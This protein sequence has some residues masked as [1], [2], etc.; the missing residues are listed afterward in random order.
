MTRRSFRSHPQLLKLIHQHHRHTFDADR[1]NELPLINIRRTQARY[2]V[3]PHSGQ[4]RITKPARQPASH[5]DLR[6]KARGVAAERQ[7]PV[8]GRRMVEGPRTRQSQDVGS[9]GV[10]KLHAPAAERALAEAAERRR[11]A[12]PERS[13]EHNGRGGLEPV[14]YGDWEVKGLAYDF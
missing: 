6:R 13:P 12:E 3:R 2:C 4:P 5:I 1:K 14:R 9:D 11:R 7:G 8:A 10:E